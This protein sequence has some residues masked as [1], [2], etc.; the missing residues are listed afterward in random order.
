MPVRC[1]R[2]VFAALLFLTP[3]VSLRVAG[4]EKVEEYPSGKAKGK[5]QTTDAGVKDGPFTEFYENE[6]VRA[7]GAYKGGK[8]DGDH[9]VYFPSGAVMA[10]G[11]F[12]AGTVH[13]T[14]TDSTPQGATH[15]IADYDKGRL[16]SFKLYS[17]GKVVAEQEFDGDKWAPPRR[18][19][20]IQL[21]LS[22]IA[23][24]PNTAKAG[25]LDA[26]RDAGLRRLMAYRA[27]TGVPFDGLT[28]D[29]DLN[30]KTSAAAEF[31]QAIGKLTHT[32]TNTVG[33]AD[34]KFKLAD[35]GCKSS[36]L[37]F[38]APKAFIPT[39]IDGLMDDSD[40]SNIDR[41]GHRR[42]CLNPGMLKTGL[43]KSP[44][45][46]YV[47][48]W[49]FDTSR[50]PAPSHDFVAYPPAGF[51]SLS[52]FGPGARKDTGPEGP[53]WSFSPD[54]AKFTIPD[55]KSFTVKVFRKTDKTAVGPGEELTLG[56]LNVSTDH[57]GGS[58]AIIFRP[59]QVVLEPGS[60]YVV[61]IT[62]LATPKGQP[63]TMSY[64]VIFA[65]TF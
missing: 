37:Y 22:T 53:A 10:S 50:K 13:G 16:R 23:T 27:A 18:L 43:G 6:K 8:L 17:K 11:K 44:N 57:F 39:A 21:D 35:E 19:S 52:H 45:G 65:P 2:W 5:Y 31:C 64:L 20:E 30:A 51:A 54:P 61:E 62:G 56:V 1:V 34:E 41:L 12:V 26:E 36:N 28:L 63:T 7:K 55:A 38:S 58:P 60:R 24:T 42:W 40:A 47:A 15:L 49:A 59:K 46:V 33:W 48:M 32:P 9:T 4:A 29:T 25:T 3:V 14:Y